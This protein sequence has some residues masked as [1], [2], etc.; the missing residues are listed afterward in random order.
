MG[1]ELTDTQ[2][3]RQTD[4]TDF[5]PST[6]DVR[7][8]KVCAVCFWHNR[9]IVVTSK[10]YFSNLRAHALYSTVDGSRQGY[11]WRVGEKKIKNKICL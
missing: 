11:S 5:I 10:E 4:G 6:T 3:H 9:D 2:T 7:E 8:E 1:R